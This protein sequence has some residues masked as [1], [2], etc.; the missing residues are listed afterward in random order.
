[1]SESESQSQGEP[2]TTEP[3]LDRHEWETEMAALEDE[4]R[5][6]PVESLP[7]LAEL[8]G[9]MLLEAGYPVD[10]PVAGTEP[11]VIGEFR[12]LRRVA[13]AVSAG[14]DDDLGDVADAIERL[15]T[16]YDGLVRQ[17]RPF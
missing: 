3:G 1:V 16:I 2:G 14:E 15:T 11:E 9:R 12:E 7:Y 4:I 13:T 5:D 10:D 8:V 17:D 6:S